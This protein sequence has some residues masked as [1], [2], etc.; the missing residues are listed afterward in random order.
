M[1][2]GTNLSFV[3]SLVTEVH[4]LKPNFSSLNKLNEALAKSN[5]EGIVD[6]GDLDVLL[7]FSEELSSPIFKEPDTSCSVPKE[8]PAVQN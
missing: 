6:E 8:V 2:R 1:D 4:E 5:S 3:N 7:Q